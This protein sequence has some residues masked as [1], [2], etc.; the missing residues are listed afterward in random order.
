M[1][2]LS[3]G[4]IL[5]DHET[6]RRGS[7]TGEYIEMCDHCFGTISAEVADVEDLG[8]SVLPDEEDEIL[9]YQL[10]RENAGYL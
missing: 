5:Q 4:T 1:R 8:I 7:V 6:R 10:A 3:C 2:C 9:G